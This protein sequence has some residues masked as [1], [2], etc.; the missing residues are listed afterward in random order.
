M[1]LDNPAA[2]DGFPASA[3]A[4]ISLW[5]DHALG[6][7]GVD[8]LAGRACAHRYRPHFHDETVIAVFTAGA[9][10]HR[11]G[12][13]IGTALPGSLMIIPAGEVHT[14]EAAERD[15]HWSYRA[16]YPDA[17]TLAA[18]A[19][20]LFGADGRIAFAAEPL[21]D[22][23]ALAHR[24]AWLHRVVE[25]ERHDVLARQQAFGAALAAM[26]KRHARPGA[27]ERRPSRE[28]LAI[29]RARDCAGA[30]FADSALDIRMLAAAAGLSPYRFMRSFRAATGLTAHAYVVQLRL[31]EARRLLA[32]GQPA[33]Q[34]AQAVGF[35]D[36]S[37][38]IRQ[39]RAAF[40]L[41]PGRYAAGSRNRTAAQPGLR[42]S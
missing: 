20:E 38:L 10:R 7:A 13:R 26:L 22:D 31:E 9:Q 37:H 35:A 1:R 29:R 17:A 11:I 4:G 12:P 25:G 15:G 8:L 27:A 6:H 30:N 36:Q 33:A 40:G 39:F 18:L 16:F 2:E 5:R 42:P 14:G 3:A 23:A 41:T 28:P 32:A 19:A 34:V 24:L 21:H